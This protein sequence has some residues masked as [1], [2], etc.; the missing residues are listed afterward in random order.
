M[1]IA[2]VEIHVLFVHT[3]P[4]LKSKGQYISTEKL[5]NDFKKIIITFL[6]LCQL[7]KTASGERADPE[8]STES[9]KTC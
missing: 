3:C 2:G 5:R 7:V 8:N 6:S 4:K 9:A 1:I